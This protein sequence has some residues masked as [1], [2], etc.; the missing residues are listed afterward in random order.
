MMPRTARLSSAVAALLLVGGV[1]TSPAAAATKRSAFPTIKQASPKRLGIGDTL[2]ITGTNFRKGR[3]KTTVVFKR[4]GGRA[5]FV[6]VPSATTTKLSFVVPAKLLPFLAQKQGKP[7]PTRFRL[8]VLAN[9]FGKS[10]TTVKGSPVI[11]ARAIGGV[12]TKNDCDG[13]RVPN[14]T[15]DD[16]DNDLLDDGLEAQLK[17]DACKRDSDGDG[18][19]DGWEHFSA[20]D[21]NGKSLPAPVA[22][23]Y[24]NALFAQ[25]VEVDHDGDG[26]SDVSEYAA[27][28]TYGGGKLRPKSADPYVSQLLYSGGNPSSDGRARVAPENA[29]AD[30]DGN[31]FLSDLER[32]AD[33]DRIPN[34]DEGGAQEVAAVAKPEANEPRYLDFGVFTSLYIKKVAALGDQGIQCGGINQVPYYCLDQA[35]PKIDVQRV[36]SLDWLSPDTDG[37]GI[38]DDLD[39]V[40]HDDVPNLEEFLG[41]L[42]RPASK[43]VYAHLNACVPN[44]N[45]RFCLVGGVDVDGDGVD[46][47]HDD[48]DDGDLLP[49][50]DEQRFGTNVLLADSD[51]DKVPD[52]F[53]Y[54]SALDLNSVALPFPDKRPYPN[55]LDKQD[56][57]T[58]FDGDG[59]KLFEEFRAWNVTGRPVPLSY[60]DGTQRTG[61]GSISD[62]DKDAD[63]D[64]LSNYTEL[65]GPMLPSWWTEFY[66]GKNADPFGPGVGPLERPYPSR[67]YLGT[68]FADRDSDGDSLRDGDDDEDHDGFSN[69]R[70]I[71]RPY[72]W[73]TTYTSDRGARQYG[74]PGS[75]PLARMHPFN[76]CKPITSDT[77]HRH[78]PAG[79]YITVLPSGAV[80][81]E[82]WA[83]TPR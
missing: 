26:L 64:G 81:V 79:Y 48:D 28:A 43:R 11:G 8:R 62:D 80:V 50:V 24:P 59:M 75:N 55:P 71:E 63:D 67:Q 38:R 42:G 14:D 49:D 61:G 72:D 33:G 52:G 47:M 34:I 58:D 23:P 69:L 82:D 32:D 77:C 19:S 15:D 9:R 68:D 39:D 10:F 70:E 2:T 13:D 66:N 29:Y 25:G 27:W 54:Q 16:D 83:N 20:V 76:P 41:E 60:S 73:A 30:R 56:G 57:N 78:P 3:N 7:V 6:K 45:S 21:R 4:D 46:N 51:G 65:S 74:D 53:E 36:D 5:I 1:A 31:L 44:T 35:E 22:K 12:G 37:D 40:D 17:T 18:M